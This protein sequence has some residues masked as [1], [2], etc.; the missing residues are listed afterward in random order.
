MLTA[1]LKPTSQSPLYIL[2]A[3]AIGSLWGAY[4][5]QAGADIRLIL[6]NQQTVNDYQQHGG[7]HLIS[8]HQTLVSPVP[9]DY[10]QSI[11]TPIQ[12]LLITTKAP[13]TMDALSAIKPHI[14]EQ[15]VFLLLQN[16]LGI[17]DQI[18]QEFPSVTVLQGST[19]EGC[20]RQ[21]GFEFV[22]AGHGHTFIGATGGS[23]IRDF[24]ALDQLAA[25][26]SFPPLNVNISN[27]IDAVL[28]RK[29]AVNCAINPLT[30]IHH[31]RNGELL[32]K[33]KAL[34]QM[35]QIVDE[36]LAVSVALNRTHWLTNLHEYVE[37]VAKTTADNRSSMLQDIEAG[38]ETEIDAITG[39]LCQLAEQHNINVPLNQEILAEIKRLSRE[40]KH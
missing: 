36:I 38:R 4:G 33:P 40:A 39:Y 28:W 31:C 12:N 13:Q 35:R 14:A 10:P 30:V 29:L 24:N 8:A 26:L 1:N 27:D 34:A 15:A 21:S 37:N 5:Y 11:S 18:R 16:G 25:S 2:G 3:G 19:T 23:G 32:H 7:I 22:H 9:A 20:Y 17:A 6:R